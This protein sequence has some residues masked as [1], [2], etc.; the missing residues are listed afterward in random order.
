MLVAW[1]VSPR[2]PIVRD[3]KG[4]EGRQSHGYGRCFMH[5]VPLMGQIENF[6]TTIAP[7]GL[8]GMKRR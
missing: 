3:H 4:P 1:G 5:G 2:T 6:L 8:D 7:P